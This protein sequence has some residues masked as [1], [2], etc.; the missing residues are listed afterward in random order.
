MTGAF[1]PFFLIWG[2]SFLTLWFAY[3]QV[4]YPPGDA[5]GAGLLSFFFALGIGAIRK[6]RM[7]GKDALIVARVAEAPVDGQRIAIE[8]TIEPT[9]E[10][11]RAPLSGAPCVVYDYSM[12]HWRE[13]DTQRGRKTE[14]MDRSGY[15]LAACVIRCGVRDIHLLAFPGL[16]RFAETVNGKGFTESAKN[17]V[18]ATEFQDQSILSGIDDLARLMADS[19]GIVRVDWKTSSYDDLDNSRLME[20]HVPVGT[21]VCVVGK[22]SASRNAIVPEQNVG[23][24][25]LIRGNGADAKSFVTGSRKANFITAAILVLLPALFITG[26]LAQREHWLNTN[27]KPSVSREKR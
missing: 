24:V 20:R 4:F 26:V 21:R 6:G 17:Y 25:R 11:L 27:G 1:L 10:P 18:A 14:V 12:S 5:V 15:G 13:S 2:A 19:S 23:G 3:H 7:E 22:Y 8:G 9:G 16:E